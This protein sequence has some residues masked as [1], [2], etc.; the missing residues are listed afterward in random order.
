MRK[1]QDIKTVTL[2]P[3]D[4]IG[5]EI[6]DAARKTID[7]PGANIGDECA[8]FEAV[9]GSAP[10]IAGKNIANPI[11]ITLS[12]ALLLKYIGKRKEAIS[13]EKAITKVLLKE[14]TVT[15][16]IGGN[17]TTT[18]FADAVIEELKL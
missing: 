13:I 15:K 16:D 10:D 9:H 17:A 8:V 2:I 18:E 7:A 12:G 11:A 14:R 4:G 1:K 6:T 5:Q 3:G